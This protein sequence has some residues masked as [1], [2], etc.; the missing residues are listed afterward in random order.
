MLRSLPLLVQIRRANILVASARPAN[1][2]VEAPGASAPNGPSAATGP[3]I[4]RIGWLPA[5]WKRN[6]R[7]AFAIR[8]PP[9]QS[10][11][12]ASNNVNRVPLGNILGDPIRRTAADMSLDV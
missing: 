9:K 7:T 2:V 10:C 1:C 12:D 11:A 4:R 3:W 6:G 8:P 5:A